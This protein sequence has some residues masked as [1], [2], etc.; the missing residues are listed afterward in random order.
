MDF[1]QG[2]GGGGGEQSYSSRASSMHLFHLIHDL[3]HL[4]T[5][6]VPEAYS[7]NDFPGELA[8]CVT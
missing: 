7:D 2:I 4:V 1:R 8:V 6:I 3:C 5:E